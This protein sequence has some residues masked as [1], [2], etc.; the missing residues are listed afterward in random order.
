MAILQ[1]LIAA[2]T[3]SAGK[4]LNTVFAWAT[5]LLFGR[6]SE[7]R[8]IYLSAIAFGSVI[9]LLALV[10]VAFPSFAT[11]M[12]SFVPLPDWVDKNWVRLAMLVA[13]VLLPGIIG[14]LSNFLLDKE[15][16]PKGAA[17]TVKSV[18][19]GYPYTVGLALTLVMMTAFAPIMKIR[20]LAKRWTSQHVPV[21]IESRDYPE[22]VEATQRAL[23]EGGI[24]TDRVRAGFMLRAPTKVLTFFAGGAVNDLVADELTR[25]VS[26]DLEVVLHPSD[27]VINGREVTA[28][29]ARAIIAKR[30]VFTPAHLTWDK[31]GNELEDRLGAIWRARRSR[32]AAVSL[33]ELQAVEAELDRCELPYEEWEVLFRQLLLLERE[34]RRGGAEAPRRWAAAIGAG[35]A[36][37]APH[38]ADIVE[39]IEEAASRRRKVA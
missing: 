9:W 32:P 18:L 22:V 17:A 11:F 3:R 13:A 21:I 28:A 15:Q 25:L 2:L 35:L 36:A 39:S 16:R 4:L 10:G 14:V 30:L 29:H 37:A 23:A 5:V 20:A 33:R 24:E 34:L 31:E 19:R 1:A 7:G 12:L 38:V 26:A 8:Q 27:L 6:V